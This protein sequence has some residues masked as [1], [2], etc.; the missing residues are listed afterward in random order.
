MCTNKTVMDGEP[1]EPGA[2][3]VSEVYIDSKWINEN[4]TSGSE[5]WSAV[6]KRAERDH[7]ERAGENSVC[8][9]SYRL[10][11]R[12]KII[13]L[14]HPAGGQVLP[15]QHRRRRRLVAVDTN[16]LLHHS[17]GSNCQLRFFTSGGQQGSKVVHTSSRH[18]TGHMKPQAVK[19]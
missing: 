10:N 19:F 14:L 9:G 8:E 15:W 6:M 2:A 1:T 11:P 12:R 17:S 7:L 4:W 3:L 5:N 13:H 16:W 18:V